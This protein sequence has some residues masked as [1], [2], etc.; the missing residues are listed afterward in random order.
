MKKFHHLTQNNLTKYIISTFFANEFIITDDLGSKTGDFN[1]LN[2]FLH[3][4]QDV[5]Y[6]SK[7]S[8]CK[9]VHLDF[10]IDQVYIK[11][12][13]I[14]IDKKTFSL[15][16]KFTFSYILMM[17][18]ENREDADFYLYVTK[19]F[20]KTIHNRKLSKLYLCGNFSL[21][22]ITATKT[23][24]INGFMLNS[25]VIN[26]HNLFIDITNSADKLAQFNIANAIYTTRIDD[27]SVI[28]AIKSPKIVISGIDSNQ[29]ILIQNK[30][31]TLN[32]NDQSYKIDTKNHDKVILY[33]PHS[34]IS[35]KFLA[36]Q[37]N[38]IGLKVGDSKEKH[39][40]IDFNII[41]NSEE[42]SNKDS[43]LRFT[44]DNSISGGNAIFD[45]EFGYAFD[46]GLNGNVVY[47]EGET[48]E[49][50]KEKPNYFPISLVNIEPFD[51]DII[52][53]PDQSSSDEFSPSDEEVSSDTSSEPETS[54][55][56]DTDTEPE[57][58]PEPIRPSKKGGGG[59]S[60]SSGGSDE[61]KENSMVLGNFKINTVYVGESSIIKFQP[62]YSFMKTARKLIGQIIP[63]PN[64]H[65]I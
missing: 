17:G 25:G 46:N 58:E 28:S 62:G 7:I 16:P 48:G 2:F 33:L 60:G 39:R 37:G 3:L 54:T 23:L 4:E 26:T 61:Q 9:G 59:S 50:K 14:N 65:F 43:L 6:L 20:P 12:N 1:I 51:S 18:D 8:A 36:E 52:T 19:R 31:I 24:F 40:V 38:T 55:E 35:S 27:F 5:L 63:P 64:Y 47:K 10:H 42:V 57:P 56:P 41:S 34:E 22:E 13:T 11:E 29:N 49:D 30:I 45:G 44:L 15:N 53:V 21:D 32:K